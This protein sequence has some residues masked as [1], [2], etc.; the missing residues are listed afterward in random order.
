MINPHNVL[1][2]I[3]AGMTTLNGSEAPV[4]QKIVAALKGQ[5]ESGELAAGEML[6]SSRDLSIS[7]GISRPTIAKAYRVLSSQGYIQMHRG[8]G[9]FVLRQLKSFAAPATAGAPL[10]LSMSAQLIESVSASS[11][12][13]VSD[14]E[15]PVFFGPPPHLLPVSIW[16]HLSSRYSPSASYGRDASGHANTRSAVASYLRRARNINAR[17]EDIVLFSDYRQALASIFRM[18]VEPG[19]FVVLQEPGSLLARTLAKSLGAT[20]VPFERGT[21]PSSCLKHLDE[22]PKLVLIRPSHQ[23]PTGS[24]L[25]LSERSRL[26]EWC[27]QKGIVIVEDDCDHQIRFTRHPAPP[28]MQLTTAN[29]SIVYVTDFVRLL[30]PMTT[31]SAVLASA[32]FSSILRKDKELSAPFDMNLRDQLTLADIIDNGMLERRR[33]KITSSYATRLAACVRALTEAFG[34]NVSIQKEPGSTAILFNLTCA[35]SDLEIQQIAHSIGLAMRS[36]AAFYASRPRRGEFVL[37]FAH[38]SEAEVEE[39]MARLRQCLLECGT[40]EIDFTP[41]DNQSEVV[42]GCPVALLEGVPI[43]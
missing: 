13:Q 37:S 27:N 31:V 15:S 20:I 23:L 8:K 10:Q 1:A 24:P 19:D 5:I 2:A 35:R 6:P 32:R 9:T 36:T 42:V 18:I 29:E 28:L 43:D 38:Q 41:A 39:K 3:S 12:M 33:T 30:Y 17:A 34:P 26:V 11:I 16:R 7:L 4:Y 25:N 21:E 40:E 14:L 22:V